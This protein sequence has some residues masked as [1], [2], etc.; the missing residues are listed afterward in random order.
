MARTGT[1]LG[2]KGRSQCSV[3]TE[4]K[5]DEGVSPCCCAKRFDG[6]GDVM[7]EVDLAARRV[8]QTK[9]VRVRFLSRNDALAGLVATKPTSQG[10]TAPVAGLDRGSAEI[11][12][13]MVWWQA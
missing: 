5:H 8:E 4:L 9:Y 11:S 3:A 10:V 6:I 12:G 1:D 7:I 13:P 2:G